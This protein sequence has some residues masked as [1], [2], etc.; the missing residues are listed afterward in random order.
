MEYRKFSRK[1]YGI[2]NTSLFLSRDRQEQCVAEVK[3]AKLESDG[4]MIT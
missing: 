2:T 1:S 4:F 3:E